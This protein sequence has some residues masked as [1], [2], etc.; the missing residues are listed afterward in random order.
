MIPEQNTTFNAPTPDFAAIEDTW[1]LYYRQG[2]NVN[3]Q[4]H[5]EHIG[6]LPEAESRGRQHCQIM[7]YNFLYIRP[8]LTNLETAEK[9]RLQRVGTP[10]TAQPRC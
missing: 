8:F 5:F 1:I 3:C 9:R 10:E 7:G 4:L 6:T 2:V